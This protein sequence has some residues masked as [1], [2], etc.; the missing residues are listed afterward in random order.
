MSHNDI[1]AYLEK[2]ADNPV[3]WKFKCIVAHEGPLTK[4]HHNCKGSSHNVCI[5]WENGEIT[6]KPLALIAT[7]D[8]VMCAI[9]A[10]YHE[11]LDTP[12]WKRFASI[13]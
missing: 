11:L 12:G 8:P 4:D 6:D 9:C 2:D 10:R 1:L 13:A 5:E 3:V 7:D